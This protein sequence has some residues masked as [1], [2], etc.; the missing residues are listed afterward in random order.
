MGQ[1]NS[2]VAEEVSMLA[3]Q[4]NCFIRRVITLRDSL[5][6]TGSCQRQWAGHTRQ[7]PPLFSAD[8]SDLFLPD[9]TS[10][11]S[12]S[13]PVLTSTASN[14]QASVDST[15]IPAS[16]KLRRSSHSSNATGTA[17]SV[18][19]RPPLA[20]RPA[21]TG[22][23]MMQQPMMGMGGG[24]WG[25]YQSM[26]G[27]VWGTPMN[28]G[29]DRCSSWQVRFLHALYLRSGLQGVKHILLLIVSK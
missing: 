23:S 8:P 17:A 5:T 18:T 6:L 13:K 4:I 27:Y 28:M 25:G 14:V 1:F 29:M 24:Q 26:P 19:H 3:L 12:D 22:Y 10:D 21:P 9:I 11:T 7:N 2:H 15:P 16:K 20:I